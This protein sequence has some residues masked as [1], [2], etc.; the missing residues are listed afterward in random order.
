MKSYHLFLSIFLLIPIIGSDAFLVPKETFEQCGMDETLG[1]IMCIAPVTTLFQNQLNLQNITRARGIRI[2]N[3]CRNA[4]TCLRA[5]PC[6][7]KVQMDKV[8]NLLCDA[9]S[10]F[11]TD[12][13]SCQKK[14]VAQMPPCMREAEKS[15]MKSGEKVDHPCDLISKHKP[16]FEIEIT[17]ICGEQYW[18]PIDTMLGKFQKYLQLKC[19]VEPPEEK[20]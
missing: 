2:A 5:F 13:A 19:P 10:Y 16:C 17:N 11:S 8:F 6:V 3:E 9:I 1:V 4:T 12:F 20:F 15:V 7:T 14:L 18:T